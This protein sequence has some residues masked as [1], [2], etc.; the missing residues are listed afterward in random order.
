MFHSL[1]S[2]RRLEIR[3]HRLSPRSSPDPSIIQGLQIDHRLPKTRQ[4]KKGKITDSY[5]SVWQAGTCWHWANDA[6][7][8]WIFRILIFA[9]TIEPEFS[10]NLHHFWSLSLFLCPRIYFWLM[11][12][13]P[14]ASPCRRLVAE[15]IWWRH[16]L[17][18]SDVMLC[19][20]MS[21][22]RRDSLP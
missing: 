5:I 8:S 19:L 4:W 18:S 7:S 21:M 15:T 6:S 2:G 11:V 17:S 16:S 12:F 9:P 10:V 14:S 22:L 3:N 20:Q 13:C 1:F